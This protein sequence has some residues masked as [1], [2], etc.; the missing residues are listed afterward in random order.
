MSGN[1]RRDFLKKSL[2]M[3][4]GITLLPEFAKS[5][6]NK[7]AAIDI[8]SVKGNDYFNCTITAIEKLGGISKFV[9]KGAK[10]GLL[11]NAP[12]WWSRPGSHT[13]TD[14]VLATIKLLNDAG[15][16]EIVWLI[17]P[18]DDF[19]KRSTRSEQFIGLT[20]VIKSNSGEHKEIDIPK[21]V[22]L[23]SAKV[24]RDLFDCDVFINLPITKH[25]GGCDM[26]NNLKNFMGNCKGETNKFFHSSDDEFLSQCIADVN[27][28]RKPDLCIC[29]ATEVLKTNGPAGPGEIIKPQTVY[30]GTDPVAMDA[31]GSKLLGAK[32]ETI[33]TTVMAAKHG[34]GEMELSKVNVLETAI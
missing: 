30:V 4:A 1:N 17:S 18:A 23:K 34:L 28:V 21:G 9:S 12:N 13:N 3:G 29:D 6:M 22:S 2:I 15:V 24:I 32:P 7:A 8:S 27:L 10:V 20:N 11:H 19:F 14:V 31:Y 33:R 16:K 5:N 25:H 26:S